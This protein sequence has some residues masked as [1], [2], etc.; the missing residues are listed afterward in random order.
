VL[1]GR[2][3]LVPAPGDERGHAVHQQRGPAFAQIGVCIGVIGAQLGQRVVPLAEPVPQHRRGNPCRLIRAPAALG[4]LTSP[5]ER[6]LGFWPAVEIL[7]REDPDIKGVRAQVRV[8]GIVVQHTLCPIQV[9]ER[10]GMVAPD[11]VGQPQI[12]QGVGG[13]ECVARLLGAGQGLAGGCLDRVQVAGADPLEHRQQAQDPGPPQAGQVRRRQ[14]LSDGVD[15]IVVVART[16]VCAGQHPVRFGPPHRVGHH[17]QRPAGLPGR[18]LVGA[19]GEQ[20]PYQADTKGA[21]GFIACG[22]RLQFRPQQLDRQLRRPRGQ[23]GRSLDQPRPGPARTRPSRGGQLLR[24][25]EGIRARG[26]EFSRGLGVQRRTQRRRHALIERLP[27]Q[28]MPEH[29]LRA[30]AAHDVGRHRLLQARRQV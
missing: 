24:D 6:Q 18:L 23:C 30:R 3:A 15:R 5:L 4:E 13:G 12:S 11:S 27:D 20:G 28:R 26:R 17:R 10:C 21:P 22:R 1:A 2:G 7:Q 9:I 25:A 16:D 8:A 19:G 14:C 29:Q